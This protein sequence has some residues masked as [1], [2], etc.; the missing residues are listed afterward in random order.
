ML[1]FNLHDLNIFFNL[2]FRKKNEND[3]TS[4]EE[5]IFQFWMD[6][7]VEAVK[8]TIKDTIRFPVS[9]CQFKC[10]V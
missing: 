2:R 4:P 9:E 5:S 8:P 3:G 7:F 1:N 10:I 6:F